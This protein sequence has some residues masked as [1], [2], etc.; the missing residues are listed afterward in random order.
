MLLLMSVQGCIVADPPVFEQPEKTPPVLDLAAAD[1]P[2]FEVLQKAPASHVPINVPF[3]SEDA[4]VRLQAVLFLNYKTPDEAP[5]PGLRNLDPGT[6]GEERAIKME[7]DVPSVTASECD[8][9]TLQVTHFD[10]LDEQNEPIDKSDV[11]LATWWVEIQVEGSEPAPLK[12]C[13]RIGA[14]T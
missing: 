1:P 14:G 10:N 3:R 8:Q 4:G 12:D 9:L 13:P 5:Q 7:W 6:F 2:I 11:G